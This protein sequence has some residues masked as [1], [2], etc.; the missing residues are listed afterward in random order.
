M[1]LL[2]LLCG[3]AEARR[4]EIHVA[5]FNHRLR[6]RASAADARL[7]RAAAERLQVSFH[8]EGWEDSERKRALKEHGLEQAARLA[9]RAFYGRVA[10]RVNSRHVVLAH[11]ADDQVE[12]FFIRL[13]RGAG[14]HGLGG[15]RYSHKATLPVPV[16][17]VRPLLDVSRE[18]LLAWAREE[19]IRYREDESNADARFVRNRIRHQLIPELEERF[20][21][22][23]K[24]CVR[25]TMQILA[26][27]SA[28][29]REIAGRMIAGPKPEF[30]KLP[31]PVQRQMIVMQ[32]ER[33]Q[34]VFDFE[35]VEELRLGPGTIV[36]VPGNR[37]YLIDSCG[38]L[39]RQSRVARAFDAASRTVEL[40]GTGG[41]AVFD[42]FSLAW[43][44]SNRRWK[45]TRG[46]RRFE[47]FDRAR[48]GGQVV[49]RY[50][51]PGDRFRPI[52]MRESVKLQDLFT[53]A[54]VPR[55]ERGRRVVA[56][57]EDGEIF[58]VEGL[59]IGELAKVCDTTRTFLRWTWKRQGGG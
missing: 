53:N 5:H 41:G 17:I 34:V 47:V 35:T 43:T 51:Q 6:G 27:E 33:A 25:Q 9:R 20:T 59:R 2:H 50:W 26:D 55:E 28:W 19:R 57:T 11:H 8:T 46:R 21:P 44:S 23:L 15:M 24:R 3:L 45:P 4:W 12:L 18:E 58:W 30:S 54:K 48:L 36:N 13:F 38:R 49:L 22:A 40:N 29:I 16:R 42:G 7:V 37:F 56:E 31:V 32:L 52:G 10:E 14:S 1:V 39:I